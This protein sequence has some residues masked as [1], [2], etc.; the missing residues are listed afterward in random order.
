MR[1]FKV[2]AIGAFL[3]YGPIL[4]SSLGEIVFAK[5]Q[6]QKDFAELLTQK[7]YPQALKSWF[8]AYGNHPF[9]KTPT[10]KA[11]F[12]WLLFQNKLEATGLDIFLSINDPLKVNARLRKS[13]KAAVPLNHSV[14]ELTRATWSSRQ[15]NFFGE[16]I[17][18]K[19]ESVRI[20]NLDQRQIVALL[21][22]GH[23][24]GSNREK[25]QLRLA[26][27]QILQ[28]KEKEARRILL[29][30]AKKG[31]PLALLTMGRLSYQ[32]RKWDMALGFYQKVPQKSDYWFTAQEEMAWTYM[33]KGDAQKTVSVTRTITAPDFVAH[34]GP[35]ALF[36]RAFSQLKMCQYSGAIESIQDF[37]KH[38]RQ[39]AQ[40]LSELE[41]RGS[42]AGLEAFLNKF[43]KSRKVVFLSLGKVGNEIPRGLATNE[44]FLAHARLYGALAQ[45]AET[46]ER[47]V[48]GWAK[49]GHTGKAVSNPLQSLKRRVASAKKVCTDIARVQARV[50][51]TEIRETLQNVHIL[52]VEL[53]RQAARNNKKEDKTKA[54]AS[55]GHLPKKPLG[56]YDMKFPFQGEIWFDEYGGHKHAELVG[57]Q[58]TR[59]ARL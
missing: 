6:V 13:W 7:N 46:L 3:L 15:R 26:L 28:N 44:T 41:G 5:N 56:K 2:L 54:L 22:R 27:A 4:H 55:A 25:L 9:S 49:S 30:L 18:Q 10:G 45:E 53:I 21:N 29:P 43:K 20:N 33:Q 42:S 39:K 8:P 16:E 17:A 40:R 12:A 52:E 50:E 34:A 38:F 59:R 48:L 31:S 19:V 57:C 1:H 23:L 36:L 11:L 35:E 24:K 37:G 32:Q 51:L 58:R 14:W 47:E